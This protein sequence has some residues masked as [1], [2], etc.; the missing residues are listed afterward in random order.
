MSAGIGWAL[1]VV[2]A[3]A[4]QTARFVLQKILAGSGLSTGGATFSRFLF[5]APIA[6]AAALALVLG[7][8]VSVPELTP[9]FWGFVLAGGAGQVFATFL[10]VALFQLRNFAVG[11]AFTKTETVQVA[12]FSALILG[13]AVSGL[14]WVAILMGFAG[15]LLMSRPPQGG[16][17]LGRSALYGVLAG[18]GFAIAAIG[19]RGATVELEP[20][21]FVLRAMIALAA[22]TCS[23]SL[24]MALYLRFFEPGELTRV[25]R[26]WRRTV[27]VGIT[28]VGGSAGWFCAFALQNAAYV[29]AFGQIEMIFTL[30]ASVLFF[31]ER[32]HRREGLGI[33]L[34]VLSLL[35]L[36]L[37]A[38]G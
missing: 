18:A 30:M 25:L 26:A 24:G 33:A 15:V 6:T 35:L 17:W 14:G 8:G 22:A 28:G 32:L 16:R 7:T 5:G 1:L 38:R 19:Y 37:G 3:S 21:P 29:R 11:V 31:N 20:L 36:V 9:R 12:L 2:L 4:L 23:Q 13:E 10:T 34:V 27:W